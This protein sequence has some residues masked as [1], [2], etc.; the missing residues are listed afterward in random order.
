MKNVFEI[1]NQARRKNKLKRE[2]QDNEKK[3]RDNT[4]RVELLNNL[5]DYIKP[6]MTHDEI[7]LIVKN[8]KADYEDRIDDHIIKSAEISKVRRE[9]SRRIRELTEEDKQSQGKK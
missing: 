1:V 9:I 3:V 5:L 4:K 7:V 2:L 6:E 8:M